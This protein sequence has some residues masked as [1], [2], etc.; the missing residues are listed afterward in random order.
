MCMPAEWLWIYLYF[1]VLGKLCPRI[2]QSQE[3]QKQARPILHLLLY[4]EQEQTKRK[5][6]IN[7]FTFKWFYLVSG[8]SGLRY[9]ELLPSNVICALEYILT[10]DW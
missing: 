7:L 1:E 4:K 8:D 5:P 6:V 2:P 9:N 10:L 3:P